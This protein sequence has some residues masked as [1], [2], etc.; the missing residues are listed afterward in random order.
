M[1]YPI[2]CAPSS[3]FCCL[4]SNFTLH[5]PFRRA[6]SLP[7]TPSHANGHWQ[8]CH[9]RPFLQKSSAR[10][11]SSC[12]GQ[13][14]TRFEIP[15]SKVETEPLISQ[16]RPQRNQSVRTELFLCFIFPF[17]MID[18]ESLRVFASP[19]SP[20]LF[21]FLPP[22]VLACTVCLRAWASSCPE[23]PGAFSGLSK[24]PPALFPLLQ[25]SAVQ[26]MQGQGIAHR[27]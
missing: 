10:P 5:I 8:S 15:V 19:L 12:S 23:R 1:T 27:A 7:P 16:N 25:K 9:L 11:D 3:F 26:K 13:T 21:F 18:G 6:L 2:L 24:H 20:F 4:Y 17:S 14:C 22:M